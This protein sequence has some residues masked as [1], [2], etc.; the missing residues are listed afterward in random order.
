M[1]N[2][3]SIPASTSTYFQAGRRQKKI[4]T[5]TTHFKQENQTKLSIN[6]FDSKLTKEIMSGKEKSSKLALDFPP[7]VSAPVVITSVSERQ[8]LMVMG[9]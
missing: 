3:E 5:V 7:M 4:V 1:G 2:I 8:Q 6:C 9:H